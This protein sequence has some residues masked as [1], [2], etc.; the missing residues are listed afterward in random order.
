MESDFLDRISRAQV[1]EVKVEEPY[2][3]DLVYLFDTGGQPA[4]H[5][6]LPLFFPLVMFIIFVLKLSK[7]LDH[8]PKVRFF[9][10]GKP[11]GAPYM[12]P[13]SHL[14]IA[15]HSF[16]AVQSQMLAQQHSDE[17]FPKMMIVGTHR[18]K[19]WHCSES[20]REKNRKLAEILSP[21]FKEH[22]V[23]R[24]E[25]G[26]GKQKKGN[27]LIF[28]LDA[29][30]RTR[31]DRKV[32][33]E[34][35][36]AITM[37][38]SAIK[39]KKTPLS[40]HVLELALRELAG[41]L[42]RG[43][44]TRAECI[45]ES[46]KLD[47]SV[48]VFDAALN[49]F[50]HLNTILYYHTVLPDVVFIQAQPLMQK[51][52]EL[53]QQTHVLRGQV[54]DKCTPI[55]GKW[56]KF[57]DEGIV[58]ISILESFPESYLEGVFTAGDLVRL[59]KY[60]LLVSPIDQSSYFMPILLP[61][62]SPE[63][64][65]QH[66]AGYNSAIAP[67]TILFSCDL[68]PTGLFCSLVSSLLSA[69]MPPQLSLKASPSDRSLLECVG[70][71]CIK[72][73]LDNDI[74]L[75]LINVYSHLELHLSAPLMD[76][77]APLCLALKA[78]VLASI[79]TA[80]HALHFDQLEPQCG[81]LCEASTPRAKVRVTPERHWMGRR[82]FG[83][84]HQVEVAPVTHPARLC[85][86]RGWACSLDRDRIHGKLKERHMVWLQKKSSSESPNLF[87][88]FLCIPST[89]YVASPGPLI[90]L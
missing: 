57:R 40:W 32:A 78:K 89:A 15:Q 88:A 4:F 30:H 33:T 76:D 8:H 62:L 64:V 36:Q 34:I 26:K 68:V 17:G 46:T 65:S 42:G 63:E 59:M 43:F 79:A 70:S 58:T 73:S 47:I 38:T 54:P 80:T 14:E 75:V 51:I 13:L 28:P 41:K 6:I 72:F 44:L 23:Y 55:Q 83:D 66:R 49:H 87:S 7:K 22:L 9:V 60:K 31:K 10:Q 35:R 21:S 84:P 61:D 90:T 39:R 56:L 81:F 27:S 5:A 3:Y 86:G 19:E 69:V 67:L 45:T 1:K 50:V 2:N 20:M 25:T 53:I 52:T 18:D 29:K 16:C 82:V 85:D 11:V 48:Q 24:S 77:P 74:S 12:S 37:A 71:N